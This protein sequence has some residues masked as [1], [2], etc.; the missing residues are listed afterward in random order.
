MGL[1]EHTFIFKKKK[2]K[3]CSFFVQIYALREGLALLAEEGLQKCWERHRIC[4]EKLH[5]GKKN[6]I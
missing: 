1:E 5:Q 3:K 4:A 2:K 6:N